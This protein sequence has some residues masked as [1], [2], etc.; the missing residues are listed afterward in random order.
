MGS[1]TSSRT[2]SRSAQ[3]RC[4]ETDGAVSASESWRRWD[5]S[6]SPAST[7]RHTR[8]PIGSTISWRRRRDGTQPEPVHGHRARR[9]AIWGGRH[10]KAPG[11]PLLAPPP[12]RTIATG[13]FRA[14]G[15]STTARTFSGGHQP[16]TLPSPARWL[17]LQ[18]VLFR[19][20]TVRLPGLRRL[21]HLAPRPETRDHPRSTRLHGRPRDTDRQRTGGRAIAA[22]DDS[23]LY[24]EPD[25]SLKAADLTPLARSPD[26]RAIVKIV[27]D[28]ADVFQPDRRF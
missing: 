13:V 21:E 26:Q 2:R 4:P 22:A 1:P 7:F 23:D 11:S 19:P 27:N 20:A 9:L 28:I 10:P 18:T 6:S 3:R 12:D 8:N 24:H 25:D 14:P 16:R 17:I 15:H 5:G